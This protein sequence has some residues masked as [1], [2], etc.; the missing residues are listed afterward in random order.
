[1]TPSRHPFRTP[2]FARHPSRTP[3]WAV[4]AVSIW[5]LWT[6]ADGARNM[7]LTWAFAVKTQASA[8]GGGGI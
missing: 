6:L 7:P 3:K 4:M 5:A 2:K 1:M 8:G